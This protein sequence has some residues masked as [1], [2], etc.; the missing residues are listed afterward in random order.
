TASAAATR[1]GALIDESALQGIVDLGGPEFLAEIL[2]D[3]AQDGEQLLRV[4]QTALQ[5]EDYPG[6]QDAIHAL[7]GSSVQM[8]AHALLENCLQ[9]EALKPHA[10]SGAEILNI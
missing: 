3:F 5:Q 9:A 1:S 10:M 8:G 4:I 6:Y 2:R 7:K